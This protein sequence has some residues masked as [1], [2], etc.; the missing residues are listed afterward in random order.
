MV[1]LKTM[2][3]PGEGPLKTRRTKR[4]MLVIENAFEKSYDYFEPVPAPP[5]PP[6][7]QTTERRDDTADRRLRATASG[8][9]NI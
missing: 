1:M 8:R 9:T 6:H 5:V 2:R 7:A 3:L 4:G